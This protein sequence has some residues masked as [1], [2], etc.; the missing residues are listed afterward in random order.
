MTRSRISVIALAVGLTVSSA[1]A[2]AQTT[3]DFANLIYNGGT[4]WS[5]FAATNGTNCTGGDLC[6]TV[7]GPLNFAK[8]GISVSA[9]G[10]YDGGRGY[11]NAMVVQDHENG[12]NAAARIGAGLGVYH[13]ITNGIPTNSSDDNVTVGE[14][15]KLSFSNVI[16]LGTIQLRSD[17][18]DVN[19]A[20]NTKFQYSTNGTAW[21]TASFPSDGVF[22][23][24]QNTK[25]F[26]VRYSSTNGDQFYLAA[27]T[28]VP[29]PSTWALMGAGLVAV[30]LVARRRRKQDTV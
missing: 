8:N 25:D 21:T 19:W 22:A 15:L 3:F 30:G 20:Q 18:H 29:E 2:S 7:G 12:Y 4:S 9:F 6:G 1:A 26:Y 13:E 24:N 5:G 23:V 10:F 16:G 14:M 11:Q 27:A 17:G 28:V